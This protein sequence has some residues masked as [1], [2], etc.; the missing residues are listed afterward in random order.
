MKKILLSAALLLALCVFGADA[1]DK[2]TKKIIEIGQTD[3]QTMAHE[4]FLA[5]RIGG[6]PVGSHALVDAENWV[7]EKL[8]EWGLE[9]KVQDVGQMAVSFNR[10]PWY[11]R[12]V[13]DGGFPLRFTTPVYSAGTKG[14]QKGHV[15]IEPKTKKQFDA[16]KGR[17]KGAWVLIEADT[18]GKAILYDEK[19]NAERAKAIEESDEAKLKEMT[20][21]FYQELKAAGILGFI[22]SVDVPIFNRQNRNCWNVTMDN[23]PD[24]C[25]ILLDCDQYAVI[26]RKVERKEDFQLEFDI[27][28]HFTRGPIKYR[29]VFGIIRGSKYP[30]EYVMSG[31]HLDSYDFASGAVDDGNGVSVLL[32]TARM[33]AESGAKPLRTIIFCFWTGEEYGQLGSFHFVNNKTIPTEKISNY[34]NR[35]ANTYVNSG[36]IVPPAM[37]DDFMKVC[38]PLFNLNPE[39]PF[40]VK[41]REGGPQKRRGGGSD[42]SA[43][44]LAGV[45]SI[46]FQE[47]DP[48]GYGIPYSEVWHTDL[49]NY[50]KVI[51]EYLE[52]SATVQAVVMYGVANLNHLLSREDLYAD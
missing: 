42:Y 8:T 12:L 6:R 51:P 1:Q 50:T 40:E 24:L 10:G 46:R 41:V 38:E 37:K 3:N 28:N 5:N 7:V 35:D 30:D 17:L 16:I 18:K 27:R 9:V 29:N 48:K 4:D 20:V 15:V 2:V 11:G 31:A 19:S 26:R 52:H 45:P 33:L 34:F 49:D 14:P 22:Q 43:F 21:P 25:D 13:G 36:L 47:T 23:L 32:E 44:V 39:L